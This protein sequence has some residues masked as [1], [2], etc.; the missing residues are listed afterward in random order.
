MIKNFLFHRVNPERDTLWDPMDVKLFDKTIQFIKNHYDIVQIEDFHHINLNSKVNRYATVTFDDGYKDNIEFAAPVLQKHNTKASFYI[1]TD[2]IDQNIPTWTHELKHRFMFTQKADIN[3]SFD[4]LPLDFRVKQISTRDE[5]IAYVKKLK[6]LLLTISFEQKIQVLDQVRAAYNDVELPQI[7]MSW[8]DL[9]QL[10][11]AGHEIGSHSVSHVMLGT[12]KNTEII[13]FEL[14]ESFKKIY[15]NLSK[16]PLAVAY[17]V[18]SFNAEVKNIAK[19]VGYHYGLAVTQN[20]H[21]PK[22]HDMF[23]IPR[24]ELYNESW[25]KTRLRINNSLERMKSLIGYR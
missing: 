4:F 24:I 16:T 8:S 14:E 9:K 21:Q 25:L 11:N 22:V 7:M 12:T 20:V 6:P 17:P 10:Q 13:K 2:C 3:L 1:V 5:R 18:G 15:L 19:Q 23:E